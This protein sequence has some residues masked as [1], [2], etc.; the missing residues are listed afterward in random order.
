MA[1]ND[2]QIRVDA[3]LAAFGGVQARL[4]AAL[5][6]NRTSVHGWITS[7]REYVPPLQ[8]HRLARL[9]PELAGRRLGGRRRSAR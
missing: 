6:I 8:A 4:A 5:N 2:P 1:P 3:A 9:R 7:G